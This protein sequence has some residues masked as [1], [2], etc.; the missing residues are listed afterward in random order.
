M[1]IVNTSTSVIPI[2]TKGVSGNT[3]VFVSS[4]ADQGQLVTIFDIDGFLSSPN[5]ILISSTSNT[6]FGPGVSSIKLQQR[7]SFLTLRSENPTEWS[8]IN[9]SA[10]PIANQPYTTNGIQFTTLNAKNTITLKSLITSDLQTSTFT[11]QSSAYITDSLFTSSISMNIGSYSPCFTTNNMW[12]SGSV[13]TQSTMST[14]EVAVFQSSFSTT[15]PLSIDNNMS[16]S[17]IVTMYSTLTIQNSLSVNQRV[18]VNSNVSARSITTSSNIT[19]YANVQTSSL[20]AKHTQANS[21]KGDEILFDG[22]SLQTSPS[23]PVL[24]VQPSLYVT[25]SVYATS[26]NT[27]DTLTNVFTVNSNLIASNISTLYIPNASIQNANGSLLISSVVAG[28]ALIGN[29]YGTN[30][31]TSLAYISTQNSEFS[32]LYCQG[33]LYASSMNIVYAITD[34]CQANSIS[35]TYINLSGNEPLQI[36]NLIGSLNVSSAFLANQMSSFTMF[37]TLFDV[38]GGTIKTAQLNTTGSAIIS[39]VEVSYSMCATSSLRI[40]T[41]SVNFSTG[42]I[43]ATSSQTVTTSTLYTIGA[44]VGT[45]LTYTAGSPY[46]VGSTIS[47]LSTNTASEFITGQGTPYFPFRVLASYDRTVDGLI[48]NPSALSTYLTLSYVYRTDGIDFPGSTSIIFGNPIVQSTIATFSSST[49]APYQNFS[50][51][52]YYIDTK[53]FSTVNN[54]YLTGPFPYSFFSDRQVV[55][56][57]GSGYSLLYSSDAGSTWVTLPFIP[58]ETSCN[59]IASGDDKWVAVGNGTANTIAFSYTGTVWYPIGKTIFSYQGNS[60]AR[61]S[62]L[63][64]A[65]GEGT[66]SLA[67]SYDGVSWVGQGTSIFTVGA[68]VATSGTAWVSVG[69]G[70]N[71]I[72]YSSDGIFWTGQ[73]TSVFSV[74]G[75]GVQWGNSLWVAVGKGTNT[76]A[77]SVNGIS[78]SGQTVFTVQGNCV[79]WNGVYWLAGGQGAF[80]TAYS[81]NGITWTPSSACPLTVVNAIAWT[82]SQWVATGSGPGISVAVSP[83]PVSWHSTSS[84]YVIANA[85]SSRAF[86]FTVP[87]NS[88][89]AT[90]SGVT[91]LASSPDGLVW[92]ARTSPFT[93]STLCVAWNGQVWIAGGSGT[94]SVAYSLNGITWTGISFANLSTVKSVAYGN[95]QWI[96]VGSGSAG[97]TRAQSSDGIIWTQSNSGNFFSGSANGITWAQNVW[98][99]TGTPEG[100]GILFSVNGSIWVP[101]ATSLFTTGGCVASNGMFFLAGGSGSATLA[102]STEGSVWSSVANG[103]FSIVN[104]IAWGGQIWVAVGAGTNTLAYSYDGVHWYGLGTTLFSVEGKSVA[105]NGS[106]WV[107]TGQGANTLASSPDGITWTGQ[108]SSVFSIAGGKVAGTIL[109]NTTVNRQEVT[110]IQWELSGITQLSDSMIEKPPRT[111]QAWNS[112]AS[113]LDGY[114]NSAFLQFKPYSQNSYCMV[115]LTENPTVT[116]SYTALNYAFC[117]TD[118]GTVQIY[119]LGV[120]QGSFGTYGPLDIFQVIYDGINVNYLKNLIPVKTVARAP[121]AA[122]Y[123]GSSFNNP[124]TRLVDVEFHP[125]YQMSTL[126]PTIPYTYMTSKQ[127]GFTNDPIVFKR[128]VTES[129]LPPALW[130]IAIPASGNLTSPSSQ[131]FAELYVSTTRIFSTQT[132]QNPFLPTLSTYTLSYLLS[133]NVTVNPGDTMEIRILTQRGLGYSVIEQTLVTDSIYNLSSTQYVQLIHNSSNVGRQ[134]S[135]LSVSLANVSTPMSNYVNSNSGIEMNS[136]FMRWNNRQYG[137]SIQNQYND[138]QLRSLTYTGSLFIASDSNLKFDVEY[139]DSAELYRSIGNLPLNRYAFSDKYQS[140][141]RTQDTHQLGVLTTEVEKQF[142]AF[143]NKVDSEHLEIPD[144]QT[145]DRIQ[146]RYAHLGATQHLIQRV[147]TLSAAVKGLKIEPH[148]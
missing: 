24:F 64:V 18:L 80:S 140:L 130:E 76:L 6:N 97:Y 54:Y 141:F 21:L 120:L 75:R 65:A 71:T 17:G 112:R 9:E 42:N 144:L 131:M 16:V 86:S 88:F 59:G 113:S 125:V 122:L 109:P 4:S 40:S 99:A 134:T 29:F 77:T 128:T 115:G 82:G 5:T 39:S 28:N 95:S 104:E 110:Y 19:A 45:P 123:L 133:S 126:E 124:G 41:L 47:G 106:V 87:S 147:S 50:L 27:V 60:A 105:W 46:I 66:N 35:S 117:L 132:I 108:G 129:V 3:I 13:L 89:L 15:G 78:W 94:Y 111:I 14:N 36:N 53:L 38:T 127:S 33:P 12:V 121:G 135:D 70:T 85:V 148:T 8:V 92:T 55:I 57:G 56:V 136:G 145:V 48:Y 58:F 146:L 98:V 68:A 44:S 62:Q 139:A 37:S 69:Q 1:Y 34:L 100:S 74:A 67:Y 2:P 118:I 83:G 81:S 30:Y 61:G 43:Q 101:Q 73:G 10:F 11:V 91:T 119:E 138:M 63:W 90:G 93:T 137:I 116:T 103:F 22:G 20:V 107:A 52:N 51:S 96:A 79:A 84:E 143:V 25:G 32:S 102:Y 114:T 31:T 26:V 142:P 72:A 23:L 7:Y 49:V